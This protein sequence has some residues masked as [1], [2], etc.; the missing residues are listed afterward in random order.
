[1]KKLLSLVGFD[2]K[3]MSIKTEM[4]GGLTTFLTMSYIL[5]VNPDMM[6]LISMD[7]GAV[8]TATALASAIATLCMAFLARAPF[9]LAPGMGINAFFAFTLVQGM[10][11]SWE[12]ALTAVFIEGI[13]FIILTVFNIREAIVN[14]IPATIRYAISAGIGLFIAFI[15]LKNSGMVVSNPATFVTMG[16]WSTTTIL[17]FVGIILAAVFTKLKI[18]GALFYTI[19][20]MTLVGIPFGVTH[21]PENFSPISMP[22]SL[23]PTF[24]KFDFSQLASFDMFVVIFSLIF[25]DLFDTLGTLVGAS[26]KAGMINKDGTIQHLKPAL[27]TDSIGTTIGSILGVS[28]VTTYVESTTGI[29]AGGRSGLTALTTAMLFLLALFLSPLF[30]IIPTAATTSAL[31]IVGVLMIESLKKIDFSDITESL[32]AFVTIIM[33][34]LCFSIAEG[35]VLGM[36]T[37]VFLNLFTGNYKKISITMYVLVLLFIIRYVYM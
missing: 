31:V 22:A 14:S 20:I 26:T 37:Y 18:K 29:A 21:L 35:I 1:M 33:M 36:L 8:F 25:M 5:A 27:L 12:T 6:S 13:V 19:I 7:K 2:A 16:Q 17:A 3:T 32:P 28:T 9:A 11:Y 15:G 24:L 23:E 30:L 4:L 34:P 10:G